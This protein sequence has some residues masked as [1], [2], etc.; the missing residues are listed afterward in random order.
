MDVGNRREAGLICGR[1]ECK[2]TE[3]NTLKILG[4]EPQNNI[5][6]Y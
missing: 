1:T 2:F 4:L 5:K 6:P 3:T